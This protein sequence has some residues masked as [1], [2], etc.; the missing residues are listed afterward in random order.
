MT[1]TIK[2]KKKTYRI[3][4]ITTL[5]GKVKWKKR[6]YNSQKRKLLICP[7]CKEKFYYWQDAHQHAEE[8]K[9]CG[10]YSI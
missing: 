1:K 3:V 9:H 6:V 8:V 2:V 5:S 7:R 10:D 4:K